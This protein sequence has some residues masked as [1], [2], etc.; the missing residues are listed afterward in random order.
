MIVGKIDEPG[1]ALAKRADIENEAIAN[2]GF[3]VDAEESARARSRGRI[4]CAA[5]LPRGQGGGGWRR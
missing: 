4:L 5:P 1:C 3:L 2:P